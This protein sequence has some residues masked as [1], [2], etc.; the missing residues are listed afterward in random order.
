M[1]EGYQSSAVWLKP[2]EETDMALK[3]TSA[4]LAIVTLLLG[5]L[6]VANAQQAQIPTLQVCNQTRVEGRAAVEIVSR[7]DAIHSGI[8]KIGIEVKC[9]PRG[10]PYPAGGLQIDVDMSDSIVQGTIIGETI[11]QLTSTGKHSPTAYL[12]GRCSAREVSGCRYWLT[13]ADNGRAQEGTPDVV[14]FLVFDGAGNRVAYGT[15]PVVDGDIAV[16]PTS[17]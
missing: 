16:A 5:A 1:T 7:S 3:A 10:L 14:G 13:L 4:T 2:K 9:D 6:T 15:G 8:F 12:S 17:N 11:E